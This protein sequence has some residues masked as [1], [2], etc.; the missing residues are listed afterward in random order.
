MR[1]GWGKG[2]GGEERERCIS[3]ISIW[4]SNIDAGDVKGAVH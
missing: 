4:Y 3:V 1:R 2:K